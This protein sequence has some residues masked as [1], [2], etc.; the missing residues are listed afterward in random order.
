MLFQQ[1]VERKADSVQLEESLD[2][3][4][5]RITIPFQCSKNA[6]QDA[7]PVDQKTNGKYRQ[8]PESTIAP[9]GYPYA[10]ADPDLTEQ[11]EV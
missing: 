6:V 3:G 2:N 10:Q 7:E 8:E 4:H 11:F 9:E 1:V 5:Y